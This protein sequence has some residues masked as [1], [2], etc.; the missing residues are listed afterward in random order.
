MTLQRRPR[1]RITW[2]PRSDRSHG[3]EPVTVD[4]LAAVARI[5]AADANLRYAIVQDQGTLVLE[6]NLVDVLEAPP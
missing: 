6:Y 1:L 5:R 3:S 2:Q 4:L